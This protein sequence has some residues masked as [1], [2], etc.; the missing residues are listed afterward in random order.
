MWVFS[1]F[2]LL[3]E[4]SI[5]FVCVVYVALLM[6]DRLINRS[7]HRSHPSWW[8]SFFWCVFSFLFLCCVLPVL[9][10]RTV[11]DWTRTITSDSRCT[12][13]CSTGWPTSS[14]KSGGSRS[15]TKIFCR[16]K[17]PGTGKSSTPTETSTTTTDTSDRKRRRDAKSGCSSN[18]Y[19]DH[20]NIKQQLQQQ[21]QQH[22]RIPRITY[23]CCRITHSVCIALPINE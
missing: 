4:R 20:H 17:N 8:F 15:E 16:S 5:P 12:P 2:V 18:N 6:I 19:I 11:V 7:F 9:A 3:V 23:R 1:H 10:S 22:N 21:L 13:P 14:R